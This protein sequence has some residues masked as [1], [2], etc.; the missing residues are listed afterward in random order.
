MSPNSY[1]SMTE[2]SE[3]IAE[4]QAIYGETETLKPNL[5]SVQP[6]VIRGPAGRFLP[7]HAPKSPGRPPKGESFAEKYM[8]ALDKDA[9]A[10]IQAH[11]KRG[12][13]DGTAAERAFTLAAAYKMG[14]PKQ[15]FVIHDGDSPL[16]A[17]FSTLA[18]T[19]ALPAPYIEG[20][21]RQVDST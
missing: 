17:L 9:D 6:V 8:K 3:R 15:T 21:S 5:E 20:E 4:P 13:G 14:L 7:G 18:A 16:A 1:E 12:K 11:I 2:K 10:L 19:G